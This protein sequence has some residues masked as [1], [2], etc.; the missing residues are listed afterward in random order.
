MS[1]NKVLQVIEILDKGIKPLIKF[2]RPT[3]TSHFDPNQLARV[4]NYVLE[5]DHD[6]N[7]KVWIFYLDFSEYEKYNQSVSI[8]SFYDQ[9]KMPTLKWHETKFYPSDCKCDYFVGQTSHDEFD[10]VSDNTLVDEFMRSDEKD[11]LKWMEKEILS[12][13]VKEV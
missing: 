2:I 8:P 12:N 7:D 1:E 4:V 9:H 6:P 10:I 5:D 11:Y 13:R 3:E